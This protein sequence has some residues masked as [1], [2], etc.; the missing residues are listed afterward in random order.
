MKYAVVIEKA[1]KNYGAYVPDLP[2][3]IATGS[4]VEKTLQLIQEAIEFHIEGMMLDGE[5]VPAPQ[6]LCSYVVV[7]T[8]SLVPSDRVQGSGNGVSSRKRKK[9]GRP[10]RALSQGR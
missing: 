8:R 10:T 1:K 5:A 9:L 3:C 6:A 7:Q 4:T 2:G